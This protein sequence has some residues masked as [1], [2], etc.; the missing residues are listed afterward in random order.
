MGISGGMYLEGDNVFYDRMRK[1]IDRNCYNVQ[2]V[3]K[4]SER[5]G[6][7]RC[8]MEN[9]LF[10]TE[11]QMCHRDLMT[12][13]RPLLSS[14]KGLGGTSYTLSQHRTDNPTVR[15]T[16]ENTL[17]LVCLTVH[18]LNPVDGDPRSGCHRRSAPTDTEDSGIIRTQCHVRK[19]ER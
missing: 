10:V 7:F 3:L 1:S 17:P 14:L 6:L 4:K 15:V 19:S 2:A 8:I 18:V 11:S 13:F 12:L 9:K 16:L 5:R